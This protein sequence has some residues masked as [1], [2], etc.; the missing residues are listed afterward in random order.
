M[1]SGDK[2]EK[3]GG[4]WN[5]RQKALPCLWRGKKKEGREEGRKRGRKGGRA[6]GR[7]EKRKKKRKEKRKKAVVAANIY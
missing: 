5:K 3:G 7:K 1:L 6:G 4:I 2:Y